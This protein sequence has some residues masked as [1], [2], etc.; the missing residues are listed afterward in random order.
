M[1][2]SRLPWSDIIA[3]LEGKNRVKICGSLGRRNCPLQHVYQSGP[4]V[5]L[6]PFG[7]LLSEMAQGGHRQR[8]AGLDGVLVLVAVQSQC[9]LYMIS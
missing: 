1:G 5:S 9:S 7:S 3:V 6:M 2:I 8:Q 4:G